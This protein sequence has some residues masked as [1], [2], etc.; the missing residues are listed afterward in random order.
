MAE[1]LWV[2]AVGVDYSAAEDRRLISAMYTAGVVN[3]LIISAG[4]G[5]SASVS[6]GRAVVND[7]TGGGY[8]CYFDSVTTVPLTASTT[9]TLSVIV[10]TATGQA[11]LG[12]TPTGNSQTIGTA[13]T[14]GTGV[15]DVSNVRAAADSPASASAK[16]VAVT[17]GRFTGQVSAP[18]FTTAVFD[19]TDTYVSAPDGIR[20]GG[21]NP[22]A[23]HYARAFRS[24]TQAI[25]NSTWTPLAFN[26]V[27]RQATDY[28]TAPVGDGQ[29]F[30]AG[31]PGSYQLSGSAFFESNPTGARRSR[32]V[33]YSSAGAVTWTK[34]CAWRQAVDAQSVWFDGMFD[35]TT[36]G[37]YWRFE[38]WQNSGAAL[39]ILAGGLINGDQPYGSMRLIQAD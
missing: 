35:V 31:P 5:L 12:T 37:D 22:T 26:T 10:N 20:L 1:A 24:T 33:R 6:P 28:T 9:N 34:H 11:T 36:V 16:Y 23:R 25:P 4:T 21:A 32:I 30:F 19:V 15:T 3:G 39:D 29:Q 13:T 7:G 14:S 17:G 18:R 38:V 27:A 2:Q 8:L